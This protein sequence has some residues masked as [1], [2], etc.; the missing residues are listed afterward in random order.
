MRSLGLPYPQ[1]YLDVAWR[2]LIQNHPHDS[3]CGCSIDA[4]HEDMFYR[5]HQTRADRQ[6]PDD[7]SDAPA[8]CQRAG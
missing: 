7:R 6:P 5:F 2:W 8:G 4:V 3:I 1:G